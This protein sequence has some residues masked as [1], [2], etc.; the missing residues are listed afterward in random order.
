MFKAIIYRLFKNRAKAPVKQEFVWE[1]V[2]CGHRLYGRG[3]NIYEA[4]AETRLQQQMH[5][6]QT[7][8]FSYQEIKQEPV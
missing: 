2:D 5:C 6:A 3:E 8:H 1:C 7:G 4:T